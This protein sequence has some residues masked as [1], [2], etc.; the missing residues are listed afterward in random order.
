MSENDTL[1]DIGIDEE[2]RALG[3]P[4]TTAEE[5]GAARLLVELDADSRA[6][7]ESWPDAWQPI[8][9]LLRLLGPAEPPGGRLAGVRRRVL[10]GAAVGAPSWSV[11]LRSV[12]WLSAGLIAPAAVWLAV[13]PS[14]GG[15]AS[16]QWVPVHSRLPVPELALIQAQ[17]AVVAN[18]GADRKAYA[19]RLAAYRRQ[20]LAEVR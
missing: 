14:L 9:V 4:P 11:R 17:A 18:P 16:E 2:L 12:M 5:R 6:S 20:V 19:L 7:A 13:Q 8:H 1:G 15:K 3:E 10:S